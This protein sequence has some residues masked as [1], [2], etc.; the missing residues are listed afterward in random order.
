MYICCLGGGGGGG[1]ATIYVIG[2]SL[3]LAKIPQDL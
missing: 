3:N 2:S 1:G